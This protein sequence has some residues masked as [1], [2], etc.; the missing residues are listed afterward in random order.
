MYFNTPS[1]V[2]PLSDTSHNTSI[3]GSGHRP[4]FR[5]LVAKGL[6]LRGD[7]TK[8]LIPLRIPLY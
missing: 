8:V 1:T 2:L 7:R 5:K 3:A 4:W 6:G